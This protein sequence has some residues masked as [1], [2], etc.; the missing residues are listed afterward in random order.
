M[1]IK[2][3]GELH[4]RRRMNIKPDMFPIWVDCLMKT[5]AD[6]DP[7]FSQE[8]EKQ[9]RHALQKGI[10]LFIQMHER[11]PFGLATR[12]PRRMNDD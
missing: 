1:A 12:L 9:W 11:S 4:S 7:E 3:L 2:H 6:L 8:L 5:I 10:D